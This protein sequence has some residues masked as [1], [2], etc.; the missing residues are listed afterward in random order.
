M[1]E[2]AEGTVRLS[3]MPWFAEGHSILVWRTPW[4]RALGKLTTVRSTSQEIPRLLWNPNDNYRVHKSPQPVPIV[5]H[6]NPIHIPNPISERSILMFP[7]IYAQVFRVV[8][9]L[10]TSQPKCCM[11]FSSP[12]ARYMPRPSHSPWF[13]HP[14]NKSA[15]Y[16]KSWAED[17]G[18]TITCNHGENLNCWGAP[19]GPRQ[20]CGW[21]Q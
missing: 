15:Y 16:Y 10:Q 1:H 17:K 9:S 5:D 4:S 11:H 12:H 6:M 21:G 14:N 8:S 20:G 3:D 18:W 2:T 19:A 7:P 13:D